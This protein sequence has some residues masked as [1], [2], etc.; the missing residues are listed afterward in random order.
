MRTPAAA[1]LSTTEHAPRNAADRRAGPG[2]WPAAAGTYLL[3]AVVVWWHVWS[4]HPTAASACPCG[5]AG[6]VTWFLAWPAYAIAHGLNPF[7]STFMFHPMGV[8]LL[9]N[10]SSEAFGV[11]LAP[12]TWLF[13]PVATLN[14]SLTLAPALSALSMFWLIRRWVRWQPAAFLGGLVY[15]FAP[16]MIQNLAVGHLMS[17]ALMVPP[18]VV[19]CLDDLIVRGRR[20]PVRVGVVLGVL[21]VAQFFLG[22]EVLVIM[23]L[24]TV[25]ASVLLLGYGLA[26]EGRALAGRVRRVLAGLGSA[27]AVCVVC[28]AYPTWFALAGPAHLGGE[29]WGSQLTPGSAGILVGNLVRTSSAGSVADFYYRIAGYVGMPL[30]SGTFLGPGVLL[31]AVGGILVFRRDRRLWFFGALGVIETALSLGLNSGLRWV[32][33]NVLAKVPVVKNVLPSRIMSMTILCAAVVVA[34]VVDRSRTAVLAHM[35]AGPGARRGIV[36]ALPTSVAFVVAAVGIAPLV[37]SER[38]VLP[39]AV[40]TLRLPP[41]FTHAAVHLPGKAVL[42]VAVSG[43][44]GGGRLLV[45]QAADDMHFSVVGGA[46]PGSISSRAGPE[47]PGYDVLGGET[48]THAARAQA[49]SASDIRAVSDAMRGWGVTTVVLPQSSARQVASPTVGQTDL[50]ALFTEVIGRAP[51]EQDHAIVWRRIGDARTLPALSAATFSTCT[52]FGRGGPN[53]LVHEGRCLVGSP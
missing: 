24:S 32:P 41:W 28:L 4:T 36:M 35:A 29:V 53:P 19:G 34:V 44:D 50:V 25:G 14:V 23:V 20:N 27:A 51:R 18:L 2:T 46:G 17:A 38:S 15:G 33:W 40:S 16:L 37:Q 48:M 13:G 26:H 39:L 10:A 7:Y 52:T 42:L 43:L 5:D 21:V 30:P 12:V 3:L 6:L 1:H 45:W 47:R 8:N 11:L 22:T 31:V 9:S 49:P